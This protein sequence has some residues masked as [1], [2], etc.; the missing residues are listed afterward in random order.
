MDDKKKISFRQKNSTKCPVC[1]S[2]FYK[3][4]LF[5]GGGRLIAGK[6]TDE[7]RRRYEDNKKFGKIYP[8]AYLIS[9]CPNCLY[10][11]YPKDFTAIEHDEVEK[12]FELTNA[13]KGAVGKFFTGL[14]F[15]KDR[16]LYLGAASFMLA[17]DCYSLRNKKVAPTFK[18]A[19]SSIRAAWLFDDLAELEPEKQF[20]KISLFF[21]KKAYQYYIKTLDLIQNGAEPSEAAGNMGPDSDK[22]WGYDGILYLSSVLTVKVGSWEKDIKKKIANFELSKRYLSRLF[23][24]GKSSKS[25]PSEI[26][27]KT[28]D[29]YDKIATMLDEWNQQVAQEAAGTT[30]GTAEE[31]A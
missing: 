14:D 2:E 10:A 13:R 5:S 24:M 21:Y 15:N 9:V 16:D 11:A 22:N 28:R 1:S 7:L 19:V 30:A 26:L 20:K 3:E 29:V 6:L 31:G 8:L 25:R 27:D 17:V 4:E 23:G 12:L 18:N